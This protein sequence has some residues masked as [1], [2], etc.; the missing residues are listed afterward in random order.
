MKLLSKIEDFTKKEVPFSG[1]D[2][3]VQPLLAIFGEYL[4]ANYCEGLEY[5]DHAQNFVDLIDTILDFQRNN[6]TEKEYTDY[7]NKNIHY[8]CY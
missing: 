7:I 6:I 2:R 8:F 4:I 5:E 1:L 3:E